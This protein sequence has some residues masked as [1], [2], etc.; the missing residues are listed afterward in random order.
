MS[1]SAQPRGPGAGQET[2]AGA[3]AVA[4]SVDWLRARTVAAGRTP[5]EW[6]ASARA[7][8]ARPSRQ[9]RPDLSRRI[10]DGR[11]SRQRSR[12]RSARGASACRPT[13]AS[14]TIPPSKPASSRSRTRAASLS[15]WPASSGPA[16]RSSIFARGQ[17]ARRSRSPPRR[18]GSD[19]RHRQQSRP[20]F[21]ACA[22]RRPR[23]RG[24]RDPAAQSAPNE[25]D[26][27]LRLARASRSRPRR[28]AMFGKRHLAAQSGGAL[29]A[30]ARAARRGWPLCR[31]GCSTLPPNWCARAA[32]WFM[33]S[34]RFC[35]AKGQ[36]RSNASFDAIHRGL[37]RI[38]PLPAGRSD[39][40]GRLLT[41]G[42]DRTDGFF[43]AR[44]AVH[45]RR[46]ARK[47]RI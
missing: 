7:R 38:R 29:A 23:G 2:E 12:R 39:G 13:A 19:P 14:M 34:A 9:R 24:H 20:P 27:S 43:V 28:C 16:S 18:R 11:V 44:L 30:D 6:P 1:C 35:P 8:A 36:G 15:R 45:A 22:T 10:A 5:D 17:A 41:P 21:E 42:H 31:N 47:W 40:A 46:T 4:G 26:R 25:L 32:G 3:A 33:P 37:V